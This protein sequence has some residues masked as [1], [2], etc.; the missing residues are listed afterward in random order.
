[1]RLCRGLRLPLVA[2]MALLLMTGAVAQAPTPTNDAAGVAASLNQLQSEV[3]ELKDLVQ[4]LKLETVASRAE[5]TRLR[6]QLEAQGAAAISAN[7][8]APQVTQSLEG[9]PSPV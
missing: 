6:Q 1:M 8:A 4:Q 2:V 9:E 3:R 7:Q 5:V